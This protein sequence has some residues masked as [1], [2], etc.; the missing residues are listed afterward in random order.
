[1]PRGPLSFIAPLTFPPARAQFFR[2]FRT[3]STRQ[4]SRSIAHVDHMRTT[5][6]PSRYGTFTSHLHIKA[7][8]GS[9]LVEAAGLVVGTPEP[10]KHGSLGA[11]LAP[12]AFGGSFAP[13]APS[14]LAQT[15][16]KATS[17]QPGETQRTAEA[18]AFSTT[19]LGLRGRRVSRAPGLGRRGSGLAVQR[20]FTITF[21]EG[22]I[23]CH[24]PA[25]VADTAGRK[26]PLTFSPWPGA[27]FGESSKV[28]V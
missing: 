11:D 19:G 5:S 3:S 28:Y 24:R 6:I 25:A 17:S 23:T 21:P 26:P 2:F 14:V 16:I 18:L 12:T 7:S 13:L 20:S 4:P 9:N 8:S 1:M 15:G 10:R 22:L 27:S